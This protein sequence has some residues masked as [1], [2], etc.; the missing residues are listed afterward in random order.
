MKRSAMRMTF[1]AMLSMATLVAIEIGAFFGFDNIFRSTGS[2]WVC[3]WLRPGADLTGLD[4]D[5]KA[6]AIARSKIE[7]A[8]EEIRLDEGLCYALPYPDGFG[9]RLT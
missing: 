4:G 8:G 1:I 6:L 9:L 7:R 2:S 5:P 3:R